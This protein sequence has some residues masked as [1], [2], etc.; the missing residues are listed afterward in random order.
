M[1]A[2]LTQAGFTFG[3]GLCATGM[4]PVA[5]PGPEVQVGQMVVGRRCILV[6][7]CLI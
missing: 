3:V 6:G 5:V 1:S 2:G 4:A 7:T